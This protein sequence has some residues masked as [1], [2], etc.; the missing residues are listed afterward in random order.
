MMLLMLPACM[1]VLAS[2]ALGQKQTYVTRFDAF[3]GYAF[4]DSP[5]VSLFE[6]GFA[7]QIG[8]RPKTWYS[9]GFDYTYATG[10]LTLTADQLVPSLQQSLGAQLAALAAAGRLPPGYSLKVLS[11]SKTQ[12]FA[13]GPQLAYRRWEHATIFFRPL[14]AGA[15]YEVATPKPA[16]PI[17]T[18][19]VAQL[20]PSGKKTDTTW[21][22]GVGGGFDILLSHH[23][24]IRTQ[25]DVVHDHLFD[26]LLKDGRWTVRFSVGPA[27]NFGRNI[28]K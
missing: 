13:V 6:N 20:A 19:I 3:G 4:L 5:S 22:L 28:V 12:T 7:T 27:F 11:H 25:V 1:L 10:D 24:A 9:L 2:P 16:D 18:A 15:I 8:V 14:F 23:F 17:A 21:F 26:D